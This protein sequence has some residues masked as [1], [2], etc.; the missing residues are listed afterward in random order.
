[1]LNRRL[2]A[3]ESMVVVEGKTGLRSLTFCGKG[4]ACTVGN[5]AH[6]TMRNQDLLF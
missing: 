4:L 1:M 3:Q 6:R 5:M 2:Q